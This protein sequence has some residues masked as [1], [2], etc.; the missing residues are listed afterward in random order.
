MQNSIQLGEIAFMNGPLGH[1]TVSTTLIL[2]G[3]PFNV[4]GKGGGWSVFYINNLGQTQHEIIN[5][6][7]ELFYITMLDN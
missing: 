5:L 1:I 4:Q 7:Q 6:L 3:P 2:W